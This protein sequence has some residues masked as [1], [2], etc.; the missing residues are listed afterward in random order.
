MK[1]VFY[2]QLIISVISIINFQAQHRLLLQ[3]D[4]N[5]IKDV[6]IKAKA[7]SVQCET[8]IAELELKLTELSESVG[9]YERLKIQDQQTIQVV[10]VTRCSKKGCPL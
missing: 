7:Y 6:E 2:Y 9:N 8:R 10:H 3:E 4:E 1:S 5:R